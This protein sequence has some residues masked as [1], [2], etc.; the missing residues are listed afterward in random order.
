MDFLHNQYEEKWRK[1]ATVWSKLSNPPAAEGEWIFHTVLLIAIF[2]IFLTN[3]L[4]REQA[5]RTPHRRASRGRAPPGTRGLRVSVLTFP[6]L[7]PGGPRADLRGCKWL[8]RVRL[9]DPTGCSPQAPLPVGFSR[10]H[11]RSGL[12]ALL[13]RIF[14]AGV[15]PES[16]ACRVPAGGFLTVSAPWEAVP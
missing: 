11:H 13:Q 4:A 9:C 6:R 14:P 3:R 8:R 12:Q 5:E 2:R 10:Q 1:G 15:K 7:L 16:P